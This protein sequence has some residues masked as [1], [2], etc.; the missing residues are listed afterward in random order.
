MTKK[1]I[2]T[3]S[4]ASSS[5]FQAGNVAS[6][7]HTHQFTLQMVFANSCLKPRYSEGCPGAARPS[8]AFLGLFQRAEMAPRR[9]VNART[10][11]LRLPLLQLQVPVSPSPFGYG[12]SSSS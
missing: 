9:L 6:L 1:S 10:A 7:S 4:S 5:D 3:T 11:E 8:A 12:Q 2:K